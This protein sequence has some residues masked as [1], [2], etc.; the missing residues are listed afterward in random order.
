MRRPDGILGVCNQG[1]ERDNVHVEVSGVAL[2][3][4]R[5]CPPGCEEVDVIA[6]EERDMDVDEEWSVDMLVARALVFLAPSFVLFSFR[7]FVDGV[8]SGQLLA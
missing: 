8:E 5:Q 6:D 4:S 3:P 2:F 1:E 7:D